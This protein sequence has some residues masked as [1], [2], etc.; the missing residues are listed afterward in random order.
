MEVHIM[1]YCS[2]KSWSFITDSYCPDSIAKYTITHEAN[3]TWSS[4][5]YFNDNKEKVF[6]NSMLFREIRNEP[7]LTKLLRETVCYGSPEEIIETILKIVSGMEMLLFS[8]V[9]HDPNQLF[10]RGCDVSYYSIQRIWW[11][12]YQMLVRKNINQSVPVLATVVNNDGNVKISID[13][14]NSINVYTM[15]VTKVLQGEAFEG[16]V[17]VDPY[18]ATSK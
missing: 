1:F 3:G 12:D 10:T 16:F 6:D 8:V 18:E 13:A 4:R 7:N 14:T 2:E 11:A 15:A 9:K 5:Y 17:I